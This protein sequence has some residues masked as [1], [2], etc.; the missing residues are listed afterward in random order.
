MKTIQI[1]LQETIGGLI[2]QIKENDKNLPHKCHIKMWRNDK[3]MTL[4]G[5]AKY[6]KEKTR[7]LGWSAKCTGIGKLIENNDT[8][9]DDLDLGEGDYFIAQASDEYGR[10]FFKADSED[11]CEGCSKYTKLPFPCGCKTVA[12]CTE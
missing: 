8:V 11:K 3:A 4:Q 10:F 12:Y 9:I 2:D 1:S 5:I 6:L 7:N